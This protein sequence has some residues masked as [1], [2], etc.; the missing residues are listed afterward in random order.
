MGGVAP[1]DDKRDQ[2]GAGRHGQR[3]VDFLA[4]GLHPAH[5][6]D[7]AGILAAGGHGGG[8]VLDGLAFGGVYGKRDQPALAHGVDV[9]RATVRRIGLFGVGRDDFQ[10]DVVAERH[11]RVAGAHAR[12]RPARR[13]RHADQRLDGCGPGRKI[14]RCVHDVIDSCHA[15]TLATGGR[16]VS[17]RRASRRLL[18][19]PARRPCRRRSPGAE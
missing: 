17:A 9:E 5:R 13:G 10:I 19:R 4:V 18:L 14:G 11:E 15:G 7:R 16:P 12:M 2:P 6:R 8:H 1:F 3:P